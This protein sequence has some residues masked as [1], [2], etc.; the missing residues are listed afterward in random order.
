MVCAVEK[1]FLES[2]KLGVC[3]SLVDALYADG[4]CGLAGWKKGRRQEESGIDG[5][6]CPATGTKCGLVVAVL[7]QTSARCGGR[8]TGRAV[9]D[10]CGDPGQPPPRQAA[11][12]HAHAALSRVGI[13]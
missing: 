1:T 10:D 2:A 7:R 8:G 6:V 13:V 9:D 12:R 11:G 3:A 4:Y 5:I